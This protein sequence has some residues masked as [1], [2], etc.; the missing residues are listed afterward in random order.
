MQVSE[1]PGLEGVAIDFGQADGEKR[2]VD[3]GL[4]FLGLIIPGCFGAGPVS[5]ATDFNFSD[6]SLDS[7]VGVSFHVLT[8]AFTVIFETLVQIVG[9]DVSLQANT[10]NWAIS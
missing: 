8:N 7:K 6:L 2:T 10:V 1:T 5:I 9:G 4:G 3:V